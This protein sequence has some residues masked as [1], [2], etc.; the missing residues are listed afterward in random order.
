MSLWIEVI[1]PNVKSRL[2][3]IKYALIDFDGTISVIR[4]GWENVMASTMIEM[5]CDGKTP[6]PE[7]EAEVREYIDYSTGMLTIKQMEWL[8]EAVHKHGIAK[9]PKSPYEYKR[10]YN[11]RMLSY[12]EGRIKGLM[13]GEIK[14]DDMMIMGARSFLEEL[15][16]RGVI[17]Y[18]ASGTDHDYVLKEASA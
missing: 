12:I 15:Y 9:E 17:M 18:L 14:P 5:I 11:E 2:G 7:I 16:K 4:Q 8:A 13:S 10:I 6:T 3:R 1:N